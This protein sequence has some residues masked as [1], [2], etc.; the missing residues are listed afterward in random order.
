LEIDQ[1]NPVELYCIVNFIM[2]VFVAVSHYYLYKLF[3][4]YAIKMQTHH[5]C[6][7]EFKES[8]NSKRVI[9]NLPPMDIIKE[10]EDEE[11]EE[12]EEE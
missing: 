9:E 8:P 12:E 7:R 3:C 10:G 6:L 11:E 1:N 5:I 2:I 4:T